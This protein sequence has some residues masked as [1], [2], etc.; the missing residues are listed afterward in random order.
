MYMTTFTDNKSLMT[1]DQRSLIKLGNEF[2]YPL[3]IIE[4]CV[5]KSQGNESYALFQIK[6]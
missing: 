5:Y 6:L 4:Y 3:T 2:V 1:V